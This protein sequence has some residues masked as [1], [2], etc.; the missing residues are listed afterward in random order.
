VI[1]TIQ[2]ILLLTHEVADEYLRNFLTWWNVSL[3]TNHS[4]FGADA[5]YNPDQEFFNDILHFVTAA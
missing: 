1:G 4:I 3:A 2:R 5:D